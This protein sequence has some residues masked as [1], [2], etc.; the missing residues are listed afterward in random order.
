MASS[1]IRGI[2][3][4]VMD[5]LR[6]LPPFRNDVFALFTAFLFGE[7]HKVSGLDL[8]AARCKGGS[9]YTLRDWCTSAGPPHKLRVEIASPA[10][11]TA[12]A[13]TS[14]PTPGPVAYHRTKRLC[15]AC[16]PSP[17]SVGGLWALHALACSPQPARAVWRWHQVIPHTTLLPL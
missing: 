17:A 6:C 7:T 9:G 12:L 11:S 3:N 13:E 10:L 8:P 14:T 5:D 1:M 2:S 16:T 4:G 15:R